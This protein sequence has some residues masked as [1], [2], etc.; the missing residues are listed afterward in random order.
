MIMLLLHR[1][2]SINN[3]RYFL[4][5]SKLYIY[6]PFLPQN[7]V[8]KILPYYGWFAFIGNISLYDYIQNLLVEFRVRVAIPNHD[9]IGILDM[10][11]CAL[12]HSLCT[13]YF[14]EHI[15]KSGIALSN[16]SLVLSPTDLS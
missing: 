10:S 3:R 4:H 13:D 2:M 8:S 7:C 16:S 1:Y 5:I 6:L 11:P 12:V 15:F 14:L 9:A